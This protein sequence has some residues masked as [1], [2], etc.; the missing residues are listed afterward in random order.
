MGGV[1][2]TGRGVLVV[3]DD[4]EIRSVL[5]TALEDEGY[6]ARGAADGAEALAVLGSWT[7]DVIVLDVLLKGMD[8]GAFRREQRSR[9]L[10][11]SVPVLVTTAAGPWE[12]EREELGA[13]A[14]L[15]KPFNLDAFLARVEE[16]CR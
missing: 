10:A 13:A 14:F 2:R 6:E 4:G 9:R 11:A 1:A 5:L 7:P 3:E 16:L 12:A 8:A 15:A